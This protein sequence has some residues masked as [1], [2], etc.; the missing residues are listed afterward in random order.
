[1]RNR[2]LSMLVLLTAGSALAADLPW[3]YDDSARSGF[4]VLPVGVA[5]VQSLPLELR[6]H[7]WNADC[8]VARNGLLVI[9]H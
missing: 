6:T 5:S 9:I 2:L 3:K 1:M 4:V 7:T 8:T